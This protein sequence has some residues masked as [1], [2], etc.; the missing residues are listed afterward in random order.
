[1]P[2]TRA[3]HLSKSFHLIGIALLS[4]SLVG[5]GFSIC[6]FS[7]QPLASEQTARPSPL[8]APGAGTAQSTASP[9]TNS[10][11][12]GPSTSNPETEGGTFNSETSPKSEIQEQ[13]STPEITSKPDVSRPIQPKAALASEQLSS[14]TNQIAELP[15]PDSGENQGPVDSDSVAPVTVEG[16][17]PSP[18]NSLVVRQAAAKISSEDNSEA[19][20]R[21]GDERGNSRTESMLPDFAV[22]PFRRIFEG[23]QDHEAIRF[24]L[25]SGS[26]TK[27]EPPS[28]FLNAGTLGSM[29]QS[30]AKAEE[31][32][33]PPASE[34][35]AQHLF[36][37]VV[38]GNPPSSIQ[39]DSVEELPSSDLAM[40]DIS[41]GSEI[42]RLPIPNASAASDTTRQATSEIPELP[43]VPNSES[44]KTALD[45]E[46]KVPQGL[47]EDKA[48]GYQSI[49]NYPIDMSANR[50]SP[51]A[52]QPQARV[53]MLQT[54][55]KPEGDADKANGDKANG[56]KANGD[57]AEATA[58]EVPPV[59]KNEDEHMISE[60]FG[61]GYGCF[62]RAFESGLYVS[63]EFTFL[64]TSNMGDVRIGVT[65]QLSETTVSES[66]NSAIGFGNRT[67]LGIRGA[68]AGLRAVYWTFEADKE[69]TES[70]GTSQALPR[71]LT[72]SG[73]DAQTVDLE[74]TQPFCLFGC[75]FES[76]FGA[77]YATY[78]ANNAV[79][80]VDQLHNSLEL[81]GIAKAS[82]EISG[83]GPTLA[84]A[85]RK[86]LRIGFGGLPGGEILPDFNCSECGASGCLG[87]CDTW[88][89]CNGCFPWNIYWNGRISW[90]WADESSAALT[91]ASVFQ[92]D[93]N[94]NIASARSRD[95]AVITD[96]NDSSI[97]TLSFQIGLEYCRPIFCRS[98]L[99][100]RCGFEYQHWDLGKNV[101]QS[102]SFAF[103]SDNA[104]FGGR[105]DSIALS[106]KNYVDLTGFTLMLGLNY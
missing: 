54:E 49:V 96:D 70:G 29:E 16:L 47:V 23:D 64:S 11:E 50:T 33:L 42:P 45:S 93:G 34:P 82:R 52:A 55:S 99:V 13:L 71:F 66:A 74:I 6:D 4:L 43:L 2:P 101:A 26:L 100:L 104:N 8:E 17:L 63:N 57:K 30:N 15:A 85:G 21:S 94:T 97:Y 81:T 31:L 41:A 69:S 58:A 37:P 46:F 9:S 32:K 60:L 89:S 86:N 36:S 56:D 73:V 102:Q 38:V 103:L 106:D 105:V 67:T 39:R 20:E 68:Y 48:D 80:L 19:N 79:L 12:Q 84:L 92:H 35:L 83:A 3:L 51:D 5:M 72:T 87:E 44:A 76:S 77:R 53:A 62:S 28:D 65:D 59:K 1:M 14:Q 22:K 91:E 95:K 7:V 25:A 98:Q 18:A 88:R 78:T 27:T 40:Q 61:T 90:L 75:R 10:E 24:R